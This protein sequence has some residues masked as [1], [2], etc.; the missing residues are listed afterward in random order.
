MIRISPNGS[1]L[2]S[3]RWVFLLSLSLSSSPLLPLPRSTTEKAASSHC[4][5]I[6]NAMIRISPNGSV[7]YSSRWVLLS[8][9]LSSS[10]L[11]P[12]PRSTTDKAASSHCVTIHNAMIRISPNGSVLYSSRYGV[13][14]PKPS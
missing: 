3:S 7:L 6:P 13:I 11:R 8:L 2:Y 9:S 1:V 12:P 10:P 4:V 5:T 14:L